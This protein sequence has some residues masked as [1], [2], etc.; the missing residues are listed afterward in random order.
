MFSPAAG[1]IKGVFGV[2]WDDV[3]AAGNGIVRYNGSGWS[4]SLEPGWSLNDV[5]MHS[6]GEAFAVDSSGTVLRRG[7]PNWYPLDSGIHVPLSG[8]WGDSPEDLFVAGVNGDI[9]HF[10]G[11]QWLRIYSSLYTE[12]FAVW[13]RSP[14]DVYVVGRYLTV[15]HFDGAEWTTMLRDGTWDQCFLDVWGDASGRLFAV[16]TGGVIYRYGPWTD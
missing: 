13:G 9:Y 8:I 6:S 10:D 16:G 14:D 3:Y 4:E 12:L 7:T 5:W 11:E 2:S 15:L 1:A